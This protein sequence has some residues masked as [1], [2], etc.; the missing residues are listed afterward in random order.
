MCNLISDSI[1]ALD[2][3]TDTIIMVFNFAKSKINICKQ[4]IYITTSMLKECVN[5]TLFN[6]LSK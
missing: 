4:F 6:H 1:K 5:T 2:L 3:P